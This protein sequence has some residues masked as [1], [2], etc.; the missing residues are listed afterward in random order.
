VWVVQACGL[1]EMILGGWPDFAEPWQRF[2]R[3]PLDARPRDLLTSRVTSKDGHG[4]NEFI[5]KGN[6][7]KG[8]LSLSR[9]TGECDMYGAVSVDGG[10]GDKRCD[11]HAG[12]ATEECL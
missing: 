11:R 2:P 4:M 3:T 12:A 1:L 10:V 9:L 6:S 8:H 5:A 7:R